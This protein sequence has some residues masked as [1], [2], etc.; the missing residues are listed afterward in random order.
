MEPSVRIHNNNGLIKGP[1]STIFLHSEAKYTAENGNALNHREK[2]GKK[3]K[4][5]L[6]VIKSSKGL[7]TLLSTWIFVQLTA[8]WFFPVFDLDTD[9]LTM[10][11][12]ARIRVCGAFVASSRHSLGFDFVFICHLL[13]LQVCH[14]LNP[15]RNKRQT[16]KEK[17]T[18]RYIL[19]SHLI[20][21]NKR[22]K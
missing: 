14:P 16:K 9:G 19:N 18:K 12:L 11:L 15:K 13:W 8:L 1:K 6:D 4:R 22:N 3:K 10:A 21:R 7:G 20:F 2:M 5:L 17:I